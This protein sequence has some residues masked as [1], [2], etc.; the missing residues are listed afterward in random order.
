[1]IPSPD[2]H[3]S[4]SIYIAEEVIRMGFITIGLIVVVWGTVK[5]ISIIKDSNEQN[6]NLP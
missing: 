3:V 2:F 1:M 4:L 6:N 5:I